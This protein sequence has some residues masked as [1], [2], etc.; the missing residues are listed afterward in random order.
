[1]LKRPG[2]ALRRVLRRREHPLSLALF[3]IFFSLV[4]LSEVVFLFKYRRL[5]FDLA[6]FA[7]PSRLNSGSILMFWAL[8]LLSLAAGWR[9]REAALVNYVLTSVVLGFTAANHGFGYH[10][11]SFYIA[12]SF[13][14]L[15]APVG[16]V[17]SVD[18]YRNKR[19]EPPTVSRL[20]RLSLILFLATVY[21]DSAGWKWTSPMWK[22]G[23]S[24]WTPAM[25]PGFPHRD[26]S[27]VFDHESL[28]R[29]AGYG[30]LLFETI[31][32]ILVWIPALTII[33][34]MI[35]VLFHLAIGTVFPIPLFV[36]AVMA[37]YLG[38]MPPHVLRR[39]FRHRF[40]RSTP[41]APRSIPLSTGR[42]TALLLCAVWII[43]ALFVGLY[44]PLLRLPF[45][46]SGT[47]SRARQAYAYM[48]AIAYGMLGTQPH[49]V[50]DDSYF[51]GR[52]D[53][54][55]LVWRSNS[56]ER[57]LPLVQPD[58]LASGDYLSGRLYSYWTWPLAAPGG[59]AEARE[60]AI[61]RF[62][63]FWSET[64]HVD[65][66]TSSVVVMRKP[67]EMSTREWKPQWLKRNQSHPWIETSRIRK[68]DGRLIIEQAR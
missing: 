36:A 68:R 2:D 20:F 44:S 50:F 49:S 24:I 56:D 16:R 13:F 66:G 31:F 26:W 57:V 43:Q 39:L 21:L 58:G 47:P 12:G 29:A 53:V 25:H 40:E 37:F 34:L 15:V 4:L 8:S 10:A 19:P 42:T 45:I 46:W 1:M 55:T 17:L 59:E 32:P 14:L 23:L 41:G 30:A 27:L 67:V 22:A 51:A 64:E 35:G 3:R 61:L 60:E 28:A 54:F 65:L 6:P 18:A 9:T 11:D 48:N 33:F 7:T 63:A 38:A 52:N 5:L 62:V